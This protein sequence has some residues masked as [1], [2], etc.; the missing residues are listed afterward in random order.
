MFIGKDLMGERGTESKEQEEREGP[1]ASLTFWW[2]ELERQLRVEGRVV[3]LS[4]EENDQ[5]FASRP[6]PFQ[7]ACWASRQSSPIYDRIAL[8]NQMTKVKARY[9]DDV[10]AKTKRTLSSDVGAIPRP[11][12]WGG[13]R[14]LAD[15][16]EFWKGRRDRAN[17]NRPLP[18]DRFEYVYIKDEDY[19][20]SNRQ[21]LQRKNDNS[22]ESDDSNILSSLADSHSSWRR[23]RLQP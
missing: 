17:Q 5:N 11:P 7:L 18:S 23:Q 1:F 6:R 10:E 2:P 16:I 3:K 12:H 13:Y 15:R 14:L 20:E 8:D 4:D 19:Y 21:D 9:S 22:S